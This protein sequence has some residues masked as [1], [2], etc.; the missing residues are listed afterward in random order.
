MTGQGQP[1]TPGSDVARGTVLIVF[2]S[3]LAGSLVLLGG[4]FL[5][6]LSKSLS[7]EG[8]A[9]LVYA[10]YSPLCHQ[11]PDRSFEFLGFPM[12][13][14]GRCLGIYAGFVAGTLLYPFFRG[15]GRLDLPRPRVFF[16]LILPL[17][18][19]G[20]AGLLGLWETPTLVRSVTGFIW[21]GILP[22][23]FIPG[24][25][26]AILERKRPGRSAGREDLVIRP[27]KHIE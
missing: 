3:A 16:V 2:L 24:V 5:G 4:I 6:P 26:S 22:F 12:T 21:G 20:L 13:V 25:S 17:A 14:C 18:V 11:L 1:S 10:I 23:Y 19:D 9:S 8:L 15:F 27:G 7:K